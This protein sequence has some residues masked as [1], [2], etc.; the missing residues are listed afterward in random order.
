[1]NMLF[2]LTGLLTGCAVAVTVYL[3]LKK[4]Y[5]RLLAQ[6]DFLQQE[7]DKTAPLQAKTD[8]LQNRIRELGDEIKG[9]KTQIEEKNIAI[10]Q[11]AQES[12]R[13]QTLFAQ[14]EE[15]LENQKTEVARLREELN[16]EFKLLAGEILEEKT[17]K[18]SQ[19]NEEKL[20]LILNPLKE[21]IQHFEKKVEDTYS[22]EIREK[23]SLRKELEQIIAINRQMSDDAQKLTSALKGDSKTQGDWGEMQLERLLEKSG[24]QKDI[25]Y[26][27][28]A[29]CQTENGA[30][31]RPDYIILLPEQKNFIIDSKVSLTAY[32]KYHNAATDGEKSAFLKEHLHSLSQHIY[33]LGNKNY[34]SLYEVNSPDFVFMYIA[35]EPALTLALQSDSGLFEKAL[36]KNIVLVSGSTLLASMRTVSFIWKQENQK[37][38]V[39]EIAKESG[40]L[41]DKFVLFTEDLIKLGKI[42]TQSKE[43]Y[44]SV[45]NKLTTA[46][47]KG[48]TI[49]GKLENIKQ[50]G[51][52][53][54]KTLNP[55]LVSRS[56]LQEEISQSE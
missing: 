48:D 27:K 23:A 33:D 39:L 15:K 10:Q 47:R 31:M 45:M 40:F 9:Y 16:K 56:R 22:S 5:Q 25:H 7:A 44:D 2:L 6:Q 11:T 53:A 20:S 3:L 29:T 30:N 32:E 36:Q 8:L 35:L 21:K 55:H 50:L 14:A 34:P 46:S 52:N 13:F 26:L 49:V 51:A 1:M 24:L 38:N 4:Q 42:L 41:Y 17:R 18:F 19:I 43:S 12:V 54:S 28:Q 37:K